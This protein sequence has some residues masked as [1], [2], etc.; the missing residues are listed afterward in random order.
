M[1]N[2]FAILPVEM[3]LIEDQDN[4][5]KLIKADLEDLKRSMMP[6]GYYFLSHFLMLN[7]T[8]IQRPL[9]ADMGSK[10]VIGYSNVP[11]PK[12]AW[13]FKGKRSKIGGFFIPLGSTVGCGWAVMSSTTHLKVSILADKVVISDV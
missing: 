2:S 1:N 13:V 6:F 12:Q 9:V 10:L 11:G 7:P 3:R 5:F 4:G 8:F